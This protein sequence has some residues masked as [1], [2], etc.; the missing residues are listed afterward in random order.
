MAKSHLC[1]DVIEALTLGT[2]GKNMYIYLINTAV[3]TVEPLI[4][5]GLSFV[6]LKKFV[7]HKR[8]SG[9]SSPWEITHGRW[10]RNKGSPVYQV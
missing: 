7:P 8:D 9:C 5:R 1:T 4:K 3:Q 6:W 10:V 2:G